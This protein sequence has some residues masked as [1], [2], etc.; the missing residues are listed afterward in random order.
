MKRFFL[1]V[2]GDDDTPNCIDYF[3]RKMNDLL[4]AQ[5]VMGS[6]WMVPSEGLRTKA[7]KGAPIMVY[8]YLVEAEHIIGGGIE[9]RGSEEW[10]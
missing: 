6:P 9:V 3:M 2:T 8:G 1:P 10:K 7:H 4:L 5:G